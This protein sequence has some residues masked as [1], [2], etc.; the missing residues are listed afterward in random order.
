MGVSGFGDSVHDALR[1]LADAPIK[2]AVWIE[3]SERDTA[4]VAHIRTSPRKRRPNGNFTNL[5]TSLFSIRREPMRRLLW[6]MLLAALAA[7]IAIADTNVTGKW[8]GSFHSTGP[9]GEARESTAVMVL[10][11]S[12]SAITGTVGP[13]ENDQHMTVSGKIDG[14]KITLDGE[15]DGRAVT[16]DLV[17]AAD[18]ISGNMNMVHNGQTAK[19]KLDVTRAK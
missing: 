7:S 4:D 8:T 6:F 13:T 17:L 9:D 15:S 3:V 19:A 10:K 14:N 1:N 16:F 18:R 12:G 2:E 5:S 11:Q